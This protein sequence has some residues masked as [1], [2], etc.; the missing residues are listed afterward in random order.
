MKGF[1]DTAVVGGLLLLGFYGFIFKEICWPIIL[2]FK[3]FGLIYL[4]F[5][6]MLC[7]FATIFNEWKSG[8]DEWKAGVVNIILSIILLII[9]FIFIRNMPAE[10]KETGLARVFGLLLVTIVFSIFSK[11]K[12]EFEEYN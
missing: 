2:V 10:A 5:W 9:G 12:K 4:G 3:N 11:W 1:K 8:N 6:L 7:G